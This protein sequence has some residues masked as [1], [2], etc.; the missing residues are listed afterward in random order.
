[1]K[2]LIAC[3]HYGKIRDAFKA[4]GHNA[5]SCD[6]LPSETPGNHFQDS[7]FHV[8][9]NTMSWYWD[10]IIGHPPCPFLCNSGVRWLYNKD[11]SKNIDR[12]N[13]MENAAIFF[14]S[15]MHSNC[16]K[17]CLENPIPHRY[18]LE[19]IG[20]KY[21][22]IIQP[23][24]FG[25]GETKSTCLWLKGLP[26]LQPSNIVEGREGRI[27]KMP[28]SPERSK[29]RSETYLGVAEAMANQWG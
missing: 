25:H 1:M 26:K 14:R 13:N 28:P 29:L 27:W 15:L 20:K 11:G 4:R 8:L 16:D 17:I 23:W 6:L 10:L 9:S 5:W 2:V 18:A 3:E 19:I 12:W 21:D 7:I 22:Q 24:Q